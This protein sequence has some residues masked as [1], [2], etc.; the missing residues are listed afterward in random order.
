LPAVSPIGIFARCDAVAL[1]KVCFNLCVFIFCN[2]TLFVWPLESV[3]SR[4]GPFH[5]SLR[6]I[7]PESIFPANHRRSCHPINEDPVTLP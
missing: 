7:L 6:E 3:K 4:L 5:G 2:L 1:P